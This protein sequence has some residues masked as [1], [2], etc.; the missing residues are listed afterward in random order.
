M[1]AISESGDL[2][3]NAQVKDFWNATWNAWHSGMLQEVLTNAV[4]LSDE[5]IDPFLEGIETESINAELAELEAFNGEFLI[6]YHAKNGKVTYM[7]T[8]QR[9][10]AREKSEPKC[11]VFVLS[12]LLAV[13]V[14]SKWDSVTL[15]VTRK[16]SQTDTAN[17]I[18]APSESTIQYAI[19]RVASENGWDPSKILPEVKQN[20]KN[21]LAQKTVES[22]AG[23]YFLISAVVVFTVFH[24]IG[25]LNRTAF[26]TNYP[27]L[28]LNPRTIWIFLSILGGVIIAFKRPILLFIWSI[29]VALT[30]FN[31]PVL[32]NCFDGDAGPLTYIIDIISS[33]GKAWSA[34]MRI[35]WF[36]WMIN[37]FLAGGIIKVG[38]QMFD[39]WLRRKFLT[40]PE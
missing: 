29:L 20:E 9:L 37:F 23:A 17:V 8:S 35:S 31:R 4:F 6:D 3:D 1:F 36:N 24:Q 7:L 22:H 13:S 18:D 16:D 26:Q 38:S 2:M 15:I 10:L 27:L 33:T 30:F 11:R 32:E 12:D 5:P 21:E 28:E 39:V 25:F 40:K 19:M 14:K 34:R